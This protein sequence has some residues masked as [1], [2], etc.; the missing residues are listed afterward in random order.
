M[1]GIDT[2]TQSWARTR[3][4][5]RSAASSRRCPS[6]LSSAELLRSQRPRTKGH[7][8]LNSHAR[9]A[10]RGCEEP[11]AGRVVGGVGRVE[12]EGVGRGTGVVRRRM[13]GLLL[14]LSLPAL[15]PLSALLPLPLQTHTHT[16][17]RTHT[18]TQSLA[19]HRF[20]LPCEIKETATQAV[21][22]VY[23]ERVEV[24]WKARQEAR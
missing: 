22:S 24:C 1:S 15:L 16:H 13:K 14:S 21:H 4:R 20:A 2:T 9:G 8:C 10:T 3:C 23:R 19:L 11:R 12:V 5:S 6:L 17:T 18:H 7:A